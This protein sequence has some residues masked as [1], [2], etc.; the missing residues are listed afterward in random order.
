MFI[1]KVMLSTRGR[2]EAGAN[3]LT[4]KGK[5]EVKES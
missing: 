1:K 5:S 3:N 4:N 2:S